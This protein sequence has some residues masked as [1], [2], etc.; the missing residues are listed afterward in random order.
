[1]FLFN[2]ITF[3]RKNANFSKSVSSILSHFLCFCALPIHPTRGVAFICITIDW[4]DRFR[5]QVFNVSFYF[6]KTSKARTLQR[7]K[8]RWSKR[9]KHPFYLDFNLLYVA[10]WL[11][12]RHWR[13]A[14][15]SLRGSEAT[16]GLCWGGGG[17]HLM[18]CFD[19]ACLLAC[20]K[21]HFACNFQAF[22]LAALPS[23]STGF[24]KY[25]TDWVHC[26]GAFGG[27]CSQGCHGYLLPHA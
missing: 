23:V 13:S 16:F 4:F 26:D 21:G 14:V 22:S 2:K 15:T 1:M 25:S 3:Y 18:V 6:R 27:G 20:E 9:S 7:S 17:G 5:L 24:D 8:L 10:K 19:F 12:S 11:K